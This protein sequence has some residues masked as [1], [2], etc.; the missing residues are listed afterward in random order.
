MK[1]SFIYN[2]ASFFSFLCIVFIPFPFNL[3]E[4]QVDITEFIFGGLIGFVSRNIFNIPVHDTHVHSDVAAMYVLVLILFILSVVISL[5]L[6]RLKNRNRDKGKILQIIYLLVCYYLALQLLKYGA[7]KIF[8]NQFYLPEPNTLYTPMGKVPRDLLYWS[9]MG[10][11][12]F[13]NIFLG[14]IE[15]IAGLFLLIKRT[16]LLGLLLSFFIMINIVAVNIG[17]DIS[18]KVFSILLLF[19]TVYLMAPYL[20]SVYQFFL[21]KT[22]KESSQPANKISLF[23]NRFLSVSLKC[24][25]AGLILLEAFYPFIRSGNFN[26]DLAKRPYM[27]GA[28]EIKQI[29]AGDDTLKSADFP[30]KRFFIH[31]DSYMIF[32]DSN[33]EM[34]DYKLTYDNGKQQ[35]VLIDYKM[36][37]I[38]LQLEYQAAD[39]VLMIRYSKSGELQQLTGKAL[40]WRKL[41][42]L[43]KK[44]HWTVDEQ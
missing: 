5:I 6:L 14:A 8:K 18:V 7:D 4:R 15:M 41:P 35:Y 38:P 29:I 27:H 19:Y 31:K 43:R 28:Y 24:F 26:G 30:V 16:R 33:D 22:S 34:A 11:S 23:Q 40:D 10:T 32:Q 25:V 42:A 2:T 12:H 39:S 44:F 9:S 36:N 1:R 3:F 20:K 17:F 21:S 37:K 13:Y